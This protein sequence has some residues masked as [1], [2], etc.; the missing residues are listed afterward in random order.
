MCGHPVSSLADAEKAIGVF[1]QRGVPH[2]VI[3]LGDQ[4]VVYGSQAQP[5][6]VHFPAQVVKVVDTTVCL[7]DCIYIIALVYYDV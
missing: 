6:P 2:V 1:L 4:G 5:K 3:T 7:H